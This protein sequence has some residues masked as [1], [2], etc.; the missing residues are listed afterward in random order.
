MNPINARVIYT[1][2][3]SL[4]VNIGVGLVSPKDNRAFGFEEIIA[5]WGIA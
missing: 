4:S 1:Q 5:I 3:K 2:E